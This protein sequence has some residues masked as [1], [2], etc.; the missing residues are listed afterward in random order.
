M[1]WRA[2][3]KVTQDLT[4][5]YADLA[6]VGGAV[7]ARAHTVRVALDATKRPDSTWV[8]RYDVPV[9]SRQAEAAAARTD[10]IRRAT[11]T[12]HFDDHVQMANRLGG[13]PHPIHLPPDSGA[14][15]A[16]RLFEDVF[17][18]WIDPEL[19]SRGLAG[20]RETVRHAVVIFPVGQQPI[21]RLNNEVGLVAT[22]RAAG[23]IEAG[24]AVMRSDITAILDMVPENVDPDAAWVAYAAIGDEVII[25]FDFRYNRARA[26]SVLPRAREFAAL[27]EL[28]LKQGHLAVAVEN[29]YAAAE[30]AVTAQMRLVALQPRHDHTLKRRWF[31]NWTRL[32]NSPAEHGRTLARLAAAHHSAR[33]A[34]GALRMRRA[35]V[36]TALGAV[37]EMVD[38]VA[39]RAAERRPTQ[40]VDS[41]AGGE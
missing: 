41:P 37:R 8:G 7:Y 19:A 26:Q 23:P 11:V 18:L 31:A 13:D 17:S 16:D 27:A 33:Y 2:V 34:D 6:G 28:A 22:A 5:D 36:T 25:S 4:G 12:R 29:A 15:P 3:I 30:L 35:Q 39:A 9:C 24:Q 1:R 14:I 20:R 10:P 38:Y 21:V 32:G 40:E